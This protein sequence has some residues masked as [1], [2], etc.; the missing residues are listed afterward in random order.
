MYFT[1]VIGR[2]AKRADRAD[3]SLKILG[4]GAESVAFYKFQASLS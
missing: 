3:L 4:L 2:D 1:D